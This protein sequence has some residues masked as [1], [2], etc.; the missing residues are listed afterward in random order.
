MRSGRPLSKQSD[1]L[2]GNLKMRLSAARQSGQDEQSL[3][4][5]VDKLLLA[6]GIRG[7][8]T[9]TRATILSEF[10][11]ALIDAFERRLRNEEGD[12]SPDPKAERFPE[13]QAPNTG[14]KVSLTGL[15]EDW[16]RLE[17][18]PANLATSTHESYESTMRRFVAFLGHDDATRVGADDVIAFKDERLAAGISPKTVKDSDIAGLKSVFG[19]ALSHR[20]LPSNPAQG[21]TVKLGKK[22]RTRD[23]GFTPEE[24]K[25]IL[26]HALHHQCGRERPK[27]CAAKRWIPWLCAYTGARVGEMAQLRKQDV[28]REGEHWVITITPEAGIVKTKEM[29]RVPLHAHLIELG[30]ASFVEGAADGYLFIDVRNGEK[31]ERGGVTNRVR[32][33]VREVVPDPNVQPN[34]AWRHL[35]KTIGFEVGIQERVLDAICGHAPRHVGGTYGDV[36]LKTMAAAIA[37]LPRFEAT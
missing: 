34:H 18:T 15:V 28:R 13:W 31:P 29:R 25:T 14:P 16:W 3:G 37:K 30:F 10:R 5:M 21:I 2:A 24:A 36:T 27:T 33:F 8:D 23:K 35:F 20:R 7:V 22:S 9:E 17:A 1:D 11:R 4:P 32:E 6:K 19:F 12:Y 26:S